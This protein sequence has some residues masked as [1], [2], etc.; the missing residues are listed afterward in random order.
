MADAV[1]KINGETICVKELRE[2]WES[3]L[4]KVFPTEA[5]GVGK[6]TTETFAYT[7]RNTSRPVIKVAKPKVVIPVFPGTNCEYDTARAFERAGAEAEIF[8]LRNINSDVLT[9]SI[10]EF[11]EKINS[12]QILMIPGGFSGGDEPDGSGKFIT[13]VLRNPMVK[14]AVTNLLENRDGLM[15]GICNGFQALVKSGLLP[16][17]KIMDTMDTDSPTLT[18]NAIGRHQSQ[19][20]QTRISSVKSPWFANVNTGDIHTVPISHG[21]GRFTA[22]EALIRKM[23]EN[24]QI[25]TQYVDEKGNPTMDIVF[26]PNASDFAIEGIT[27]PDGRILGKMA[28]SE[29]IGN[30]VAINVPGEQDQK[31]FLS[32]VE[33]FK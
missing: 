29:R 1:I 19:M 17:G 25:A 21:E 15:L 5:K 30:G 14:E 20:V 24:G 26:N 27:S 33:Y 6:D 11:A 32:G 12:S 9:Q 2:K 13:A 8:V 18:F 4:L 10:K 16:Y 31:I 23:V 22:P 28:H 7:Q 3:P